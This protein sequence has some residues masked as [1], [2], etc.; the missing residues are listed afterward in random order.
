MITLLFSLL[1]SLI[2]L[3]LY[4]EVQF[5]I[6]EIEIWARTDEKRFFYL[7]GKSNNSQKDT[8]DYFNSIELS[9]L[10]PFIQE[11]SLN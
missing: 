4:A 5:T 8:D 9:D 2:F 1:L 7:I 6:R 3:L 10:Y 11:N